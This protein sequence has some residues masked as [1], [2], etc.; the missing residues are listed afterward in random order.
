[1]APNSSVQNHA[2]WAEYYYQKTY[3][4]EGHVIDEGLENICEDD[5]MSLGNFYTDLEKQPQLRKYS[6]M[7]EG[8]DHEPSQPTPHK[9]GS[10]NTAQ[11]MSV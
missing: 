5:D 2:A 6:T 4:K 11:N 8:G 10:Q 9:F 7:S 1:M 3:L